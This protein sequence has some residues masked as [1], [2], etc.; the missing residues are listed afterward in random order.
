MGCSS[1]SQGG[2]AAGGAGAPPAP[3]PAAQ[4]P[5]DPIKVF[6]VPMSPNCSSVLLARDANVGDFE[7]CD[8]MKGEQNK[9]EYLAMNPFHHIP[10]IKDGNLA[11]GESVACLRYLALKY[12]PEYYPVQ[13]AVACGVIDFAADSFATEVY[14]KL[15]GPVIYPVF[16]FAQ[17]PEDQTK[18]NE[19]ASAVVET[20]MKHFVKGKFVNGD[21]LSIADFKAVPFLFAA[22][23][24]A[25]E[26]KSG[27]K[28]SDRA[29]QYVE[30][31]CQRTG[32][33]SDFLKD[34]MGN[35]IAEYAASKVKDAGAPSEFQSVALSAAP[36]FAKPAGKNIKV[37][38]LPMSSNASG[39]V[40]L[41]MD[42]QVGAFE[43]C[44]LR[45]GEQNA[46][47][48]LAMNPFHHIPTIKDGD[49][50]I[51]ES[52]ACLR[53]LALQS[54]SNYYP[55]TE[56]AQCGMIDFACDSFAYDVY[57]KVKDVF[58]GIFGFDEPPADQA[59][60]NQEATEILATWMKHFVN[61]EPGK[62]VNGDKL[63]IAEFKAV[64][65]IFALM[66]PVVKSKVGF[67]VSQEA[68]TYVE[69]FL[70]AVEASKFLST[71]GFSIAEYAATKA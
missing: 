35:S 3:P 8:L 27:F 43:M 69:N 68:K 70:S 7:M 51:G 71:G 34:F 32:K 23:Q 64:P 29:K 44:D 52:S 47:E 11:L 42:L 50:A 25:V 55:V 58:Y 19:E 59:K 37:F 14:P 66:Q 5:A 62:F 2:G 33:T 40:L 20:W 46:P 13:D 17:A 10:T 60:A 61:K 36:P 6:C 63:S 9:P 38:G 21:K 45:K 28:L 54:R 30:D 31:F 57:P 22:M 24:P 12:K 26:K 65:F 39:P 16:G 1:S 18:A 41:A 15:G 4:P 48:F 49:F 67:E 56:P 53:Y